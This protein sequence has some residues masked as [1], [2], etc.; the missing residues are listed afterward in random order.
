MTITVPLLK[1]QTPVKSHLRKPGAIQDSKHKVMSSQRAQEELGNKEVQE[2]E[3]YLKVHVGVV[4][5]GSPAPE[6][7]RRFPTLVAFAR[8]HRPTFQVKRG[9]KLPC[10]RSFRDAPPTRRLQ[11]PNRPLLGSSGIS[12]AGPRST[13]GFTARAARADLCPGSL[14]SAARTPSWLCRPPAARSPPARRPPPALFPL[15]MS[16]KKHRKRLSQTSESGSPAPPAAAC[17]SAAAGTLL[18]TSFLEKAGLF[19]LTSSN[20]CIFLGPPL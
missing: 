8:S 11:P 7:G 19:P 6:G 2:D 10:A 3:A 14:R 1:N 17:G 15:A 12:G 16:S 18:V 13:R 9:T 20:L 5:R 4:D